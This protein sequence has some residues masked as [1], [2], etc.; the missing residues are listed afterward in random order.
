MRSEEDD[1]SHGGI[2]A[3]SSGTGAARTSSE[4]GAKTAELR[5][6]PRARAERP[7]LSYREASAALM[8]A[9]HGLAAAFFLR[10]APSI[11]TPE[12]WAGQYLF[13]LGLSLALSLGNPFVKRRLVAALLFG[14]QAFLLAVAVYPEGSRTL[15]AGLFAC[16]LLLGA[17][18]SFKVRLPLVP[19]ITVAVLFLFRLRP[20]RAWASLPSVPPL[21]DSLLI[22][23]L[24]IVF[25]C[26]ALVAKAWD[27]EARRQRA[28]AASMDRS[29]ASLLDANLDFQNY[30]LEAGE[31]ST[32]AERK[33]L[34]RDIHDIVG[35]TLINLKMMLE[36]AIDRAGAENRGLAELLSSARDQAQ[37]GLVET[38]QVLRSFR[39]ME[40]AKPEG[41]ASI[42]KIT[43]AFSQ[44]T[45]IEL[46]VSY[47]NMPRSLGSLNSVISHIVQEGITNAI[48]HGGATRIQIGFWI[49]QGRLHVKI[50]DNGAGASDI[51]P[52]IGLTGMRERLE[53]L[54]GE[55]LVQS[56]DYGFSLIAEM[57][58]PDELLEGGAE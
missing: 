25:A 32:I 33:R 16:I 49:V 26:C 19:P 31:R 8:V 44:A 20:V 4:T 22:C 57:P 10:G 58:L 47:G 2:V 28:R 52:G 51:K 5:A 39:E 37:A 17:I 56:S 1:C 9:L 42:H 40:N 53:P 23:A 55:L 45:G 48:R 34:S 11:E 24:V 7:R 3:E 50:A 12:D 30:A 46:E 27:A 36:A 21:V 14:F 18:G 43:T 54:G 35:Y 41:V 13:L 38:R 15:S 6:E 29:I